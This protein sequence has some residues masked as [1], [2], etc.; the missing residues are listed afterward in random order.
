MAK[1]ALLILLP[2]II[3]IFLFQVLVFA[4]PPTVTLVS[5]SDG[6]VSSTN[7]ITFVCNV[8]DDE[9]VYN[10]SLFNDINGSFAIYNTKNIMELDKSSDTMLMCRFNNYTCEDGETGT[11]TSTDIVQSRFMKG[12]LINGSDIL[13]Y[14]T[15]GNINY[16]RGTLEFWISPN[17]NTSDWGENVYL[18]STDGYGD[19][20]G[21]RMEIFIEPGPS[22]VLYFTFY[23]DD[24]YGVAEIYTDNP[25]G[26][27]EGEWHHVAVLWDLYGDFGGGRRVDMF[28]DGS[29]SSMTPGGNEYSSYGSVFGTNLYLGSNNTGGNQKSVVLDE[30]RITNRVLGE[31]EITASYDRGA[32]DHYNESVNWTISGIPDGAYKW[33]CLAHDNES[34][35][36]WSSNYTFYV[37]AASSPVLN[38]IMLSPSSEDDIDPNM[39]ISVIANVTDVS[40]VGSA[41]FQFKRSGV[42]TWDNVNMSNMS[43]DEWNASFSVPLPPDT[44]DYRIW[45]SDVLG[46]NATSQ[47]YNISVDYDH[48]WNVS[49]GSLEEKNIMF[50]TNGSL[51]VIVINNTGDYPLNF[52]ISSNFANTYFNISDPN[53][54]DIPAKG[55]EHI[56]INVTSPSEPGIYPLRI[57]V[58]AT[59]TNADPYSV[60][61]NATIISSWNGPYLIVSI[62]NY[63]N[64]VQQSSG[65]VNYSAKVRNIGNETAAN[66][67]IN[68]TL[69]SG[70]SNTSGNL[71]YFAGN[72]SNGSVSWNNIT[73]YISSNANAVVSSLYVNTNSS[74][75]SPANASLNVSVIC[76]NLD[77]VCGVGCSYV[78]DNDCSIPSGGNTG[79]NTGGSID[80]ALPAEKKNYEIILTFPGRLDI[81]R[82]ENKTLNIGVE[83]KVIGTELKNVY[84]SLSGYPQTF[85]KI[86][87]PYISSIKYGETKYFEIEIRAPSYA[88]NNRYDLNVTVRGQFVE[89]SKNTSA[90]KIS[91]LSL[92]THRFIENKT[93]QY[94]E[95]AKESILEMEKSGLE[96]S[97]LEEIIDEIEKSL[98]EGNYDKVKELSESVVEAKNLAFELDNKINDLEKNIGIMKNQS[99]NLPETEKMLFLSKSAF[100]RGEYQRA[101]ERAESATLLYTFESGTAGYLIIV[102]NYW[103]LIILLVLVFVFGARKAKKRM[104]V[105]ALNRK[106]DL[107][108]VE[109]N[110]IKKLILELQNEYAKGKIGADKY[111]QMMERYENSFAKTSK[112]RIDT[113]FKLKDMV[114]H[115]KAVILLTNEEK[116][117]RNS[118]SDAQSSY[119]LH[120]KLGRDHYSRLMENAK[121]ELF[122]IQS[123]TEDLRTENSKTKKGTSLPKAAAAMLVLF[124]VAGMANAAENDKAAKAIEIAEK[125]IAEMQAMGFGVTYA[126]D[127][128]SE[129]KKLYGE[130]YYEG[131][132][133]L[134]S[135]VLDIKEKAIKTNELINSVETKIY[136]LSSLGYDTS[137]ASEIFDSG[138]SEFTLDN[139]VDAEAMM[140]EAMNRLDKIEAEES[141]KRVQQRSWISETIMDYLWVLLVVALASVV[142]GFRLRE[143]AHVKKCRSEI[144]SLEAE[145][146]KIKKSI[147][148][149]QTNYFKKGSMSRIDY[150]LLIRNRNNRL[151]DINRNVSVLNERLKNH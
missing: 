64:I 98:D 93:L 149:I 127:T 30:L 3:L 9:K 134:A 86:A 79:G 90:V 109:D 52:R 108:S 70:W 116:R 78:T 104:S 82:G 65:G 39:S 62:E 4:A 10:V 23:D 29:N 124:L 115:E 144:K 13:T 50:S 51:S 24:N 146:E 71:D 73:V 58:N 135:K 11:N 41:I 140:L 31:Q 60:T 15:S 47:Q 118:I 19:A 27:H 148:D 99:V 28:V 92:I 95:A 145:R 83:N 16:S 94:Y 101:N 26:W 2:A 143:R 33:A 150:E 61:L 38:N 107:L 100:Q 77:D 106:L 74:N 114:N 22:D 72:L 96:K 97:K 5:P 151:S 43:S 17:Y 6:N 84:L 89:A 119:F 21:N 59:T 142:I 120:G 87:Q 129:A 49:P 80:L 14:P 55:K 81:N 122:Q 32:A 141:L 136:E 121:N 42:S 105:S 8:S 36:S 45:S 56:N 63:E 130:G 68:W 102:Y 18:L 66:V 111:R 137:S 1:K 25:L 112:A 147:T 125:T 53:S 123:M 48:S 138:V 7:N 67:W 46:H 88:V 133:S 131:A 103:W 128:L 35:S 37:D 57:T 139:Y 76:N 54:F 12:V 117:I 110:M 40:G 113:L 44:W 69:P 91:T 34:N 75:N 132:E 85:M 20:G 126:N